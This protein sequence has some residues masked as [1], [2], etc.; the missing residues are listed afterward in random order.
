MA[1]KDLND[2]DSFL[3]LEYRKHLDFAKR[4]GL[5]DCRYFISQ[6][7]CSVVTHRKY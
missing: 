2:K 1:Q 4:L 6:A 7:N 5:S 3:K